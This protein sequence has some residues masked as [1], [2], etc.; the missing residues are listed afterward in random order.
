MKDSIQFLRKFRKLFPEIQMGLSFEADIYNH[1]PDKLHYGYS[2][3]FYNSVDND[4]E[5]FKSKN[6]REPFQQE[7]L[8]N[9]TKYWAVYQEEQK[10]QSRPRKFIKED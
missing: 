6:L 3:S 10:R 2:F 8:K 1:A 4:Y 9:L 5:F 7:V